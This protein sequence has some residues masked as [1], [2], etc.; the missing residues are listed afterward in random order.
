MI[1]AASAFRAEMRA[2]SRRHGYSLLSSMGTLFRHPLASL[3]T[4]SVLGIS[5]TL[6]LGLHT[7]LENLRQMNS[8]LERLDSISAFLDI[9]I[10]PDD[11]RRMASHISGWASVLAVDPISPEAGM[12]ELVGATGL[13]EFDLEQV[14]LPWLLEVTPASGADTSGLADRLR[15]LGGVDLVVVDLGWV[16]RLDAILAVFSRLVEVLAVMFALAVLFVISNNIRTEI[17]ARSEEIEV[18]ALIGATPAYIRRPFL[19]S[20]LWMGLSGALVAWLL[21]GL[22]LWLLEGSVRELAASYGTPVELLAPP[23]WLV[24]GMIVGS[25]LLGILGAGIAVSRNLARINP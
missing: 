13:D 8:S 18:M 5:L 4:V 10:G 22:S 25:G 12:R 3:L 24:A 14:P 2:W 16:R 19:Y 9:E 23:P 6:P 1:K 7:A 17:Q 15:N 21:V 11:S 20:G